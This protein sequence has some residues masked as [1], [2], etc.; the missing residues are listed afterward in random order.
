MQKNQLFHPQI[1][2]SCGEI[3]VEEILQVVQEKHRAQGS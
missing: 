3:G 2:S 1:E